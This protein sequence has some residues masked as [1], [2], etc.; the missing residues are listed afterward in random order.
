MKLEQYFRQ[1]SSVL[2]RLPLEEIAAVV[3]IL[4]RARE[5]RQR[6]FLFGNGGSAADCQHIAGEM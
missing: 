6:V 3:R 4:E 5:E 1:V 2:Q